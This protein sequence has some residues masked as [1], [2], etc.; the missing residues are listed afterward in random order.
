MAFSNPFLTDFSGIFF[1]ILK[2]KEIDPSR[3]ELIV[4]DEEP[5]ER[6][7][8]ERA[9]TR[10]VLYQLGPQLNAVTIYTN[11][12]EYFFEYVQKMDEENGLIVTVLP[13]LSKKGRA[14]MQTTRDCALV[15]DFE[16]NGKCE[17][18]GTDGKCSYLPIHKK[19][20]KV[21]GNLDISVPF[22][23]N[24][25][26]VKSKHTNDKKFVNDR[27]EEGFYRDELSYKEG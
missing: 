3:M 6:H 17:L 26:I 9:D 8:F 27:F 10:D 24:T 25:V 20:W 21:A 23:Y 13:K 2:T 11:R 16:W 4:L 18:G 22:G 15:L 1:E 19:P 7:V 12:Q 5:E 14:L